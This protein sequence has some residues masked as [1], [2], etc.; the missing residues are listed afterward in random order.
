MDSESLTNLLLVVGVVVLAFLAYLA[1]RGTF[2]GV[3]AFFNPEPTYNRTFIDMLRVASAP[4]NLSPGRALKEARSALRAAGRFGSDALAA[5]I[6]E[7]TACRTRDLH[8]TLL[9]AADAIPTKALIRALTSFSSCSPLHHGRP[10]RY[11]PE[12]VGGGDIGW[13]DGTF[14]K[15]KR[16]AADA[17]AA[18]SAR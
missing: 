6:V 12:I 7:Q 5:L 17:L 14:A 4:D 9:A 2:G 3:V 15:L 13:T 16:T 1:K 8:W 18:L 11:E 10:G